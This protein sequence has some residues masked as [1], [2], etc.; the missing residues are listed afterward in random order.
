MFHVPGVL[1]GNVDGVET[2][3]H[4]GIDVAAWAV[5]DH[6]A[7]ALDDF[8]FVDQAGVGDGVFFW[9]DFDGVEKTLQPEALHVCGL[10]GGFTFGEKNQAV[11][12]S[13]VGESFRDAIKNLWRSTFKFD[14]AGVNFRQSFALG[15]LVGEFE[16]S[17]FEGAAEAAYAVAVLADI[18][19]FG[20]VEDVT[21]VGA[22]VAAGFDEG[23][24]IFDEFFE[25]DIVL[26]QSVVGVDHQGVA[27]HLAVYPISEFSRLTHKKSV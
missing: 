27:S 19:A 6:P 8:V 24:E 22:S 5:A 2:D 9:D 3:F 23:D 13:K 7:L 17:F 20:F 1:V 10:F 18:L 25:E 26:P 11:T 14:D 4:G 16:I 12:L 21:D 15:R